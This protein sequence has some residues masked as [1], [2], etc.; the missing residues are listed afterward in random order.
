MVA[1]S[2]TGSIKG[3]SVSLHVSQPA[4]TKAIRELESEFGVQLLE[5]NQWGVVPTAEGAALLN[6]AQT[7]VREIERAEEDMA[8][9]KGRR[10]GN[11]VIGVTPITGTTGLTAAFVEFRKRWPKV[12]VEFRELGFNQLSEQLQNRTVDLAF[13]AFAAPLPASGDAKELF[14]FDTVFV[15]RAKSKYAGADSLETLRE[16]EWIHTDV[17]ENQPDY[18]RAMFRRVNI[19][20]PDCITRC[21][22][23]ALFYG[24][25]ANT[26]SVFAWTQH[27]LEGT[28]LGRTFVKLPLAETP[29][30][31]RLFLL[32]PSGLQLTR[33][34][35]YFVD[36]IL[37]GGVSRATDNGRRTE[38]E[39][40]SS[41]CADGTRPPA[42]AQNR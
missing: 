36:C 19:M 13:S 41:T 8:H 16:A 40:I 27:S 7:V 22:S 37:R 11:L 42:E 9:L 18:I 29:P 17:T 31:L 21:T 4:I 3:A 1:V 34:A 14:A 35:E 20:P 10:D 30:P 2:A 33:P 39:W 32:T 28:E 12:A 24:L 26:D 23:Y 15:T 5:R 25:T 6:R 38:P